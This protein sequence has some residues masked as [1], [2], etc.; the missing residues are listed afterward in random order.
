MF[1]IYSAKIQT[2][3]I[4]RTSNPISFGLSHRRLAQTLIL[5]IESGFLNFVWN[6][7]VLA[8][9][10][11]LC[12]AWQVLTGVWTAHNLSPTWTM[13]DFASEGITNFDVVSISRIYFAKCR[14]LCLFKIYGIREH[15][16]GIPTHSCDCC[17]KQILL[18]L[19]DNNI[20][21]KF[22]RTEI[23]RTELSFRNYSVSLFGLRM[24]L[25]DFKYKLFKTFVI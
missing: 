20:D 24:K 5:E 21:A 8:L 4:F 9:H 17:P 6:S 15:E 1:L 25:F 11:S 13:R 16:F 2:L 7:F 12:G 18:K 22:N 23:T 19:D 3:V 10:M 14:V